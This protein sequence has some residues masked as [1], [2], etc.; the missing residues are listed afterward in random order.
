MIAGSV[1]TVLYGRKRGFKFNP[2]RKTEHQQ[3]QE[4]A[5]AS[6]WHT[7]IKDP[8]IYINT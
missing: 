1:F 7:H 5:D 8:D 6:E 2:F 3:I 4:I